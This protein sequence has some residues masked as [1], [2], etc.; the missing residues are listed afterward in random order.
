M[1]KLRDV[2]DVNG[3]TILGWI[4]LLL[5][6]RVNKYRVRSINYLFLIAMWKGES[7][8]SISETMDLTIRTYTNHAIQ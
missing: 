5:Q 7:L 8:V 2:D 6:T 4:F 3:T 1:L